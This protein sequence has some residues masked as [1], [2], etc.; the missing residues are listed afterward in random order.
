MDEWIKILIEADVP[1]APIN[2][3]EQALEDPQVIFRQMIREIKLSSGESLRQVAFPIK[4]SETPAMMKLPPPELGEH[5]EEILLKAGY[6]REDIQ[7]FR[8]E[9]AI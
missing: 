9:G 7:R 5:N 6:T 2:T 3:P 4:L 8:E 1:V